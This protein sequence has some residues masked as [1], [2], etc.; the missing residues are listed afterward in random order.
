MYSEYNES[1]GHTGVCIAE[2]GEGREGK[3]RRGEVGLNE[4]TGIEGKGNEVK[5]RRKGIRKT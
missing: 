4:R 3:G 5:R 1:K 2:E